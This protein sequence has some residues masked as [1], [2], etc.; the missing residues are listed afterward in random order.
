MT[1][2]PNVDGLL[3]VLTPQAV[4][5]TEATARA[6]G[7]VAGQTQK[8]VLACFMGEARMAAGIDILAAHG[9]PNYPFPGRVAQAYRAMAD[10]RCIRA[11]PI[12]EFVEFTVDQ[13]TVRAVIDGA[14]AEGRVTV[15][16]MREHLRKYVDDGTI[17][18]WAVPDK[19]V[20]VEE[21]PKTSVGKIDKKVLRSQ[22]N[23]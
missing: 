18:S 4:T 21:L 14:R 12:P 13:T 6:V 11:R 16:T 23:G 5:D 1:A 2:D 9:I 7:D 20:L 19:Y 17:T 15:E 3:V 10:Y 8:P 22:Y